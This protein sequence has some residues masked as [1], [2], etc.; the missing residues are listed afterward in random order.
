MDELSLATLIS[1]SGESVVAEAISK[2]NAFLSL[3][4]NLAQTL[5]DLLIKEKDL[6]RQYLAAIEE[7]LILDELQKDP[8]EWKSTKDA[9]KEEKE[10]LSTGLE[11]NAVLDKR[12]DKIMETINVATEVLTSWRCKVDILSQKMNELK[13]KKSELEGVD[14]NKNSLS[15]YQREMKNNL[16]KVNVLLVKAQAEQDILKDRIQRM[17]SSLQ[18]L[19]ESES[20]L[21]R[22]YLHQ[23]SRLQS[24]KQKL[25]NMQMLS[26]VECCVINEKVL[27]ITLQPKNLM[28]MADLNGQ[29]CEDLDDCKFTAD[30]MF[31]VNDQGCLE[32]SDVETYQGGEEVKELIAHVK[33]D[34]D[35][36]KFVSSLRNT[37]LSSL[38]LN[39]EV[40][41]LRKSHAIDFIEEESIVKL[42]IN[43]RN[44]ICA[45]N[46]PK[47]YPCAC[48]SLASIT[49][50]ELTSKDIAAPSSQ[51]LTAWVKHLED[52]LGQ[53]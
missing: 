20:E 2:Y 24:L 36:P 42:I 17:E 29:D 4:D 50:S 37:W 34:K 40:S 39:T 41:C 16:D 26:G 38:P 47:S 9:E 8:Q 19:S 30:L 28:S 10:L 33:Q 11:M 23:K 18:H 49:G 43:K 32:I 13:S 6:K 14:L 21:E 48:V 35:L 25:H 52:L 22:K 44:I 51:T 46:V 1:D 7:R 45:L 15:L 5:Q 12:L 27:R 31:A 3:P 53:H